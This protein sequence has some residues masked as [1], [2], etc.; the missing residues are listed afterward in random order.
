MG[1]IIARN[2]ENEFSRALNRTWGLGCNPKEVTGKKIQIIMWLGEKN[3][4]IRRKVM[5]CQ[6][7]R[8]P[9]LNRDP[10]TPK[11]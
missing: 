2:G 10:P 5:V 4:R 11:Y 9:G 6:A 7:G 3:K 1:Y 8:Y